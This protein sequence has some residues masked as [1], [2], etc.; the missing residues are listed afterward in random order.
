MVEEFF[1]YTVI[2]IVIG[3]AYAI[4]A[5]G[6]VLTY[7]TSRVFNIAHGAI[8]MFM[9]FG[10]WELA[11]NRGLPQWLAALLVVLVAAPLFGALIERFMMRG[12][13]E[14]QVSVSLVITVG[15]LVGLLGAAQ[16]IWPPAARQVKGFLPG[17]N[18]TIGSVVVSANDVIT[19]VMAILVAGGLY[20]FLSKTR[21]GIAMRAVVDSDVLVGLHGVKPDRLSTLSWAGGSALA[22][23]AGILL[24]PRVGLDY[25]ALTLLVISAYAAAMLGRLK[26]LPLTFV[27][28]IALGLA[29]S[30]VVGY[31]KAGGFWLGLQPS[32]PVILLFAI[33]LFLPQVQLRIGQ[34]RGI[35]AVPVPTLNRSLAVGV[36]FVVAVWLLSD[37]LSRANT[38]RLALGMCYALLMLS[39]LLLTGYG[40]F[41]SLAQFTFAGIGALVVARLNTSSPLA[42][43]AGALVAAAVGAL[44]A[45]PI[46]R[47][48]GLYLALGTLAFADMMDKLIFQASFAFQ[49]N[50]ILPVK[51]VSVGGIQLDSERSYAVMAAVVVTVVGI[52]LVA[53]RRGS[54]GRLLIAMRDS[55]AA[56]GTL[57]VNLTG[58]RV[59]VFAVSAGIAGLAGGLLGG[60]EQS[61][62]AT[63]FQL[64]NSLPLMLVVVVAGVTS[65][66]GAVLGGI[67]LMLL[68]VLQTR[69]PTLAGLAF[70]L[71]GIGAVAL[72]RNPNGLASHVFLVGRFIRDRLP[73]FGPGAGAPA[74]RVDVLEQ[75]VSLSGAS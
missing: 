65:V 55:P 4:A 60:L 62:G 2:G 20:V 25:Y 71:V 50:G 18:L 53:M 52:L 5:S 23:L 44:I 30:Y 63:T 7:A 66:T 8:G 69:Y 27:G 9:A 58:T 46:L 34:V 3:S 73:R 12:L 33:L 6:L 39:L 19:V 57:G 48:R 31:V 43:L 15:L 28:A 70:L 64:F 42:L 29:Q 21:L 14:A 72:G 37:Q 1:A 45:L 13:A 54:F 22:A 40:G 26:S 49:Y 38:S 36:G 10:Y 56:C 74:G 24:V 75:E 47:L 51:R 16:T 68:P 41:V 17:N 32:V 35:R 59:L 11:V 61:A 67:V